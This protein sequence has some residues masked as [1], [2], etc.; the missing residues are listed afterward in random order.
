LA[1]SVGGAVAQHE[2]GSK[3]ASGD[4]DENRLL[5]NFPLIPVNLGYW[6]IGAV[7][8]VYDEMDPVYLHM[9]TLAV[10]ISSNDIRLTPFGIYPAGSKVTAADNDIGQ[11]LMPLPTGLPGPA[12]FYN[13]LYGVANGY[14]NGDSVYIKA[15]PYPLATGFLGG[16]IITTN[17]VRITPIITI[18]V[19]LPGGAKV[20]NFDPDNNNLVQPMVGVFPI[21]PTLLGSIGT[22]R[23]FNANGNTDFTGAPIYDYP[24][25][26]YIDVSVPAPAGG[27][28][29]VSPNDVRL[30]I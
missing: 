25:A 7:P 19:M 24:D 29:S 5:D 6:D 8:A 4:A 1:L 17:D 10:P 2:F 13:N 26:V 22:I 20:K 15:T 21:P 18:T 12:I 14:D 28:G 9:G 27:T 3:V 23:F 11:L 16:T 30:T